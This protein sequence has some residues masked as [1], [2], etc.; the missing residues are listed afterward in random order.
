MF[1]AKKKQLLSEFASLCYSC[2]GV[3]YP[4]PFQDSLRI[5][6]GFLKDSYRIPIEFLKDSFRIPAANIPQNKK[7]Y[8]PKKQNKPKKPNKPNKPKEPNKPN[9]PCFLNYPA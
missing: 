7:T 9:K 4:L 5:P 2:V 3:P 8:K 6:M 1:L